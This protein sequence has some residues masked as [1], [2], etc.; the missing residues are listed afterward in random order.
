MFD[1]LY[2]RHTGGTFILRIEDTDRARYVEGSL[3]E[4][5]SGLRWLGMQWDEGP[6][7]G[8]DYGPYFQSERLQHYQDCAKQ[9]VD[10]G[11]AYYCYCTR[12]R[13][14]DLRNGQEAAKQGTGYDRR[15]RDLTPA[16]RE[17]LAGQNPN[18]V[19][20]FKMKSEGR[21]EFDDAVRGRVGFENS[22]QDDFVAIKADGFPTYHFA[23]VVDDHLMEITHVIRGDEWLSSAPKHLQLYEAFG[24]T[25]PVWVHPPLILDT[26]GKKLSK[27]SGVS[28]AVA[29]Y[30]TQGYLPD[31]MLNF[32]ATMGWSSGEDRK[33]YTRDELI[34]KFTLEG[35][36][37]HP[38]V[39]DVARLNDLQGEYVRMMSVE[40]L[41][42]MVLPYM[43]SAGFVSEYPSDEERAYLLKVTALIQE[44]LVLLNEAPERTSFFYLDDFDYEEKGAR[45]HLAKD[46][47]PA[48]LKS[49]V[50]SL[51]VLSDWNTD[52]VEAA[53]REAGARVGI[54]GGGVIH[55]V[56]MA[57]TGRTFGPG[58]FELME[59]IGKDRC[60]L[61][62]RRAAD[63]DIVQSGGNT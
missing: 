26:S 46:T 37:N 38:A 43:Q 56:R 31:A 9:L 53:V 54:E 15:C 8:G 30:I 42:E 4:I 50:D 22:L 3:E 16:Q 17:E 19:I 21:T 59:V 24:W 41:A 11:K 5:M 12:E 6:E 48:L 10:E 27:R 63:M 61:R 40:Q 55:P 47:T 60:I 7:V 57:I 13:L 2:A 44:R 20:R 23:S 58:L 36:T 51:S 62:L 34:E 1:Y 25:P 52:S 49:V 28:T 33:L 18:P 14:D 29:D 39:F 45:K 32:L 35:I